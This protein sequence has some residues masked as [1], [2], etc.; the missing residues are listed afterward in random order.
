MLIMINWSA[1]NHNVFRLVAIDGNC[2]LLYLQKIRS[3]EQADSPE[4]QPPPP[5]A[6]TVVEQAPCSSNEPLHNHVP[7]LAN[8]PRLAA[9]A[10]VIRQ[11]C[12]YGCPYHAPQPP[13]CHHCSH[14]WYPPTNA[15][16]ITVP[17]QCDV[18]EE[19]PQPQTANAQT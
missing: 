19:C 5:P 17:A 13:R 3:S 15:A 11:G 9:Q 7:I 18:E 2:T 6:Y 10:H 12:G 4:E 14:T 8:D 1:F 16:T